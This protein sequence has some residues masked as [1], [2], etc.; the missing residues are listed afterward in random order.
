MD[1]LSTASAMFG[2]LT[3]VLAAYH[4]RIGRGRVRFSS[5]PRRSPAA[6]ATR[7]RPA[8][9]S[10]ATEPLGRA[11]TPQ[12]SGIFPL[13]MLQGQSSSGQKP[14]E[15]RRVSG[16]GEPSERHHVPFGLGQR[17][18]YTTSAVSTLPPE[19]RGQRAAERLVSDARA[20][21]TRRGR[22]A[23]LDVIV[24]GASREGVAATLRLLGAGLR[25]L[26]VDAGSGEDSRAARLVADPSLSAALRA[27]GRERLPGVWGHRVLGVGTRPDAMLELSAERA[28]WYTA[29][30][31][32][33]VPVEARLER[34]HAA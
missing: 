21:R 22:K 28:A 4:W 7:V 8:G 20:A 19:Q 3:L 23:A 12:R 30:V 25:V 29:N 6:R 34:D 2:L 10:D 15:A 26:L 31:I 14:L 9:G 18:V 24:V 17:G 27:L 1:V 13:A 33:A 11:R 16:A 5:S 32:I